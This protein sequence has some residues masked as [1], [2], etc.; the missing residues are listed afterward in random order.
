MKS[1]SGAPPNGWFREPKLE[2]PDPVVVGHQGQRVERAVTEP[3]VDE[4]GLVELADQD[5]MIA[6]G[7]LPPAGPPD[8]PDTIRILKPSSPN[9]D[10]RIPFIS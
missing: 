8:R 5:Q 1:N 7:L 4:I 3:H 2:K 6:L 9:A 10:A